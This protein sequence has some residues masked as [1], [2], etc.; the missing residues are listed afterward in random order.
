MTPHIPP[1]RPWAL[2]AILLAG[3]AFAWGRAHAE[4]LSSPCQQAQGLAAGTLAP[5]T[6]ILIPV[7]HGR[8]CLRCVK[9]D[10][11]R[12]RADAD[13]R[14]ALCDAARQEQESC[15]LRETTRAQQRTR[16][17]ERCL[18]RPTPRWYESPWITVPV[19]VVIGG[20]AGW[21][22]RALLGGGR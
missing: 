14:E 11:P 21:G 22:A 19:S 7:E 15:C 10:L 4:T 20:L 5:C 13:T 16:E 6:G 9:V 17:L 12:A 3:C 18:E 2:A 1:L 8:E